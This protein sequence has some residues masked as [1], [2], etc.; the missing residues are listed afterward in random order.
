MK[1]LQVLAL[2]A[3]I[4]ISIIACGSG[5]LTLGDFGMLIVGDEVVIGVP[6]FFRN[7][8]SMEDVRNAEEKVP[9][10]YIGYTN[11]EVLKSKSKLQGQV[12]L[13]EDLENW[14]LFIG[15][16]DPTGSEARAAE[17]ARF[18]AKSQIVTFL[19]SNFLQQL[20]RT[21]SEL[22]DEIT[23][24]VK[25]TFIEETG[26]IVD[27]TGVRDLE[28]FTVKL[29]KLYRGKKAKDIVASDVY[30]KSKIL[31]G[32]PKLSIFDEYKKASDKMKEQIRS[33]EL[34]AEVEKKIDEHI[35]DRRNEALKALDAVTDK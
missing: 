34:A 7:F 16:G 33:L 31:M 22:N 35:D 19:N 28:V 15:M 26:K 10:W 12:L 14:L 27:Y 25:R 30:Y 4:G 17:D 1:R 5:G 6:P 11:P 8:S 29:T 2:A 32:I 21:S 9:W 23:T 13:G 24:K 18:A 20:T 3:V